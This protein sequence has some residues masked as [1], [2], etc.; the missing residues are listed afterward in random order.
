[1]PLIYPITESQANQLKG[2]GFAPDSFFNPTQDGSGKWFISPEEWEPADKVQWPF[3]VGIVP[4][5]YVEPVDID[6]Q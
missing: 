2:Q 1:M 3:L 4:V 6:P 5:E